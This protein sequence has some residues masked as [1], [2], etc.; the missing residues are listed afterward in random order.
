MTDHLLPLPSEVGSH[1]AGRRRRFRRSS[2]L[3]EDQSPVESPEPTVVRMST[4]KATLIA[5]AALVFFFG[6]ALGELALGGV[7]LHAINP[8][9][10]FDVFYV[11]H[12]EPVVIALLAVSVIWLLLPHSWAKRVVQ[13]ANQEQPTRD[14]ASNVIAVADCA[15]HEPSHLPSSPQGV[16]MA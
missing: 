1:P 16:P 2:H 9:H 7:V 15:E 10:H 5:L 6:L 12:Q 14:G 11:L 8:A 3:N 4:W 13:P